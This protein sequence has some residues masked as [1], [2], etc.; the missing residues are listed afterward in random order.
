MLDKN[1]MK[2]EQ[3][4]KLKTVNLE[5]HRIADKYMSYTHEKTEIVTGG[6]AHIDS[7]G[8]SV[9][10]ECNLLIGQLLDKNGGAAVI[11]VPLEDDKEMKI[12]Q[13]SSASRALRV[14]A[15]SEELVLNEQN[16][17]VFTLG[18][19]IFMYYD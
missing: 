12:R 13:S 11:V 5:L 7:L 8:V 1:G 3:Y 6:S 4:G 2:T 18:A 17:S 14:H 15:A 16:D 10:A 9:S 19:P